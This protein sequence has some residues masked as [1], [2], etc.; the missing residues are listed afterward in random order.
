PDA[1]PQMRDLF[2]SY[3]DSRLAMYRAIPDMDLVDR[4]LARSTELQNQMWS[5]AVTST[6]GPGAH[7]NA[8]VLVINALNTMIDISNTRTWAALTHPPV[9][10]FGLLFVIALI[11]AF[12]AG[13]TLAS[14]KS[15]TWPHVLGFALLTCV[16]VF[17]I[18]EIEYP[19][20]GFINIEKYDQA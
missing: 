11:C 1:Q 18:L 17:V 4:E 8:G 12:I 9:I 20:V 14:P 7:P 3:L 10:V 5:L 2:R 15:R 16:S 19:R 13:G 6:R